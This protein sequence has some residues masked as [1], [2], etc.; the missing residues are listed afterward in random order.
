MVYFVG[1]NP[2]PFVI[3]KVYFVEFFFCKLG[4]CIF[5][6]QDKFSVVMFSQFIIN[7]YCLGVPYMGVFARLRRKSGYNIF[8]F[9]YIQKCKNIFF[10]RLF[11][12][13]KKLRRN[14]I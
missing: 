12:F 8:S 6:S 10:L 4:I 11:F 3:V 5:K 1:L 13:L 2:E 7:N 9:S 14:F